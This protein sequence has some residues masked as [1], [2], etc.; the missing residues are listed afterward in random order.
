MQ[1]A[2]TSFGNRGR[3]F[4][5]IKTFAG[6]FHADQLHIRIFDEWI[7]HAHRIAAAAD[8]CN[9]RVRQT[10]FLLCDLLSCFTADDTLE[11]SHN[12]RERMR[13]EY[14]TE[15]VMRII[16]ISNP[17]AERRVDRILQCAS[18]R[19]DTDHFSTEQFHSVDVQLLAS[20]VFPAHENRTFKAEVCTDCRRCDTVLA[21]TCF[22]D[23]F[24]FAHAFCE[25][26]LP[27]RVV[28]LVSSRMIQVF[29]FQIYFRTAD[30]LR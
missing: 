28:D 7:E 16:H 5:G 12:L 15:N 27:D 14:G 25:Q 24:R 2:D 26:P 23:D 13:S 22:S 30:M 21:R 11:V 8:T 9:D 19:I 20:D 10:P 3:I 1:H 18:P 17:V 6:S 4:I 29:T